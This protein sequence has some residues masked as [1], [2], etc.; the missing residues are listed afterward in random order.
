MVVMFTFHT[1]WLYPA[2][3]PVSL[4]PP[5]KCCGIW[6][7]LWG[8]V[9]MTC[10]SWPRT[11]PSPNKIQRQG[12]TIALV[13]AIGVDMHRWWP[14]PSGCWLTMFI[15][16]RQRG[17]MI[18]MGEEECITHPN[19][20]QVVVACLLPSLLLDAADYKARCDDLSGIMWRSVHCQIKSN[21]IISY[22]QFHTR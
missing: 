20:V 16:W 18:W 14:T 7:V 15:G 12:V 10:C 4:I 21:Q 5:G 11:A 19:T 8:P 22:G 2:A 1:T 3:A 17:S 13:L 6:S 9:G